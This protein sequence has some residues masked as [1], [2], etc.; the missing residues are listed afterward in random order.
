[1]QKP[2]DLEAIAAGGMAGMASAKEKILE[3]EASSGNMQ[4]GFCTLKK[5]VAD[6][7]EEKN[8]LA[9]RWA[10]LLQTNGIKMSF[11]VIGGDD[12]LITEDGGRVMEARDF[13]L[14]QPEVAK[15]RWKDTDFTPT[16]APTPKKAS[17]KSK[18]AAAAT[19]TP[20]PTPIKEEGKKG[21]KGKKASSSKTEL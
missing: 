21:K 9:G 20:T 5:G 4:M 16:P 15:F 10:A 6:T 3:N 13:L 8:K 7:D 1:M 17:K 2:L 12:L 18:K 11:H 14:N 19:P